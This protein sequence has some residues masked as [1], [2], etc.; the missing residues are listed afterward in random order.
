MQN[1]IQT[2][3]VDQDSSGIETEKDSLQGTAF[4]YGYRRAL[5]LPFKSAV[6]RNLCGIEGSG[7]WRFMELI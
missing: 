2:K 3:A 7:F 6:E 4:N 5:S 1:A